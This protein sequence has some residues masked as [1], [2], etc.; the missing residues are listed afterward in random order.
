MANLVFR[1]KFKK[2]AEDEKPREKLTKYGPQALSLWELVALILRTGERHRGGYFEDVMQLSKRLISECGF[3]GLFNHSNVADLKE[4]HNLHKGHAEIIVAISE[5]QK[6]MHGKFDTFDA[7]EP[8]KIFEKFKSLQSVKQEQ[9]FVLHLNNNKRCVFQEMVAIGQADS[10]VVYPNDVLR[11]PIWI[12][13]KEIVIV[14]NHCGNAKA[15][16][17]DISWTLSLKQGAWLLHQ[18]KISDHV[19]IGHDGYFSFAE[20]NLL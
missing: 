12:G 2:L 15:S 17:A 6:R 8:S 16:K 9:C 20:K 3:R 19:I 1:S 11:T 7:S 4:T 18:I 5:I 14:H 10:V 13:S